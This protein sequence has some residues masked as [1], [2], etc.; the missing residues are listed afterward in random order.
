VRTTGPVTQKE[1]QVTLQAQQAFDEAVSALTSLASS[2]FDAQQQFGT[3][4]TVTSADAEFSTAVVQWAED[5]DDLRST[6]AWMARQLGDTAQQLQATNQ[7]EYDQ[8]ATLP[9]SFI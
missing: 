7:Q 4:A 5:F 6:L 8:A 1:I 2:V 9:G 3:S